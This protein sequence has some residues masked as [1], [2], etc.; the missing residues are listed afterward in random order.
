MQGTK[1]GVKDAGQ[2]RAVTGGHQMDGFVDIC[3]D[4]LIANGVSSADVHSKKSQELPGFFRPEKRWDLVAAS[5]GNIIAAIEFKSQVGSFGNNC[6]NRAEEAIGT[7]YDLLTAYEQGAFAPAPA[8]WTGFVMVLED[9]E[10]S[11]RPVSVKEPHFKVFEEFRGASYAKRY[12]ELLLRFLRRRL[13]DGACLLLSSK[14]SGAKGTYSEPCE[15]LAFARFESSLRAKA[16]SSC[17]PLPTPPPS[18]RRRSAKK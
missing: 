8:P 9:C 15:E 5:A 12:E 6:N 10:E 1:S 13:Y 7:A 2:R 17:P 18:L 16:I 3:R 4:I 14:E 11:R